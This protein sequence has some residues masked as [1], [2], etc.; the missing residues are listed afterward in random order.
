MR[1]NKR[2]PSRTL[3]TICLSCANLLKESYELA[4]VCP[5]CGVRLDPDRYRRLISYSERLVRF[6]Y[7][8]RKKFEGLGDE[9]RATKRYYLVPLNEAYTWVGLVML[10][11]IIGGVSHDVVKNVIAKIRDQ[12]K[13][14]GRT[15]AGQPSQLEL[16][17][18]Q[19]EMYVI[20]LATDPKKI[21]RDVL[22]PVLEE[23]MVDF[24][25][26][27]CGVKE[28][29]YAAKMKAATE[30][31]DSAA[32]RALVK[33]QVGA[34]ADAKSRIAERFQPPGRIDWDDLW[35]NAGA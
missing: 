13:T 14:R 15:S 32:V 10:S 26:E 25:E 24:S 27:I 8:Y 34:I 9:D 18:D 4:P 2:S 6:G 21:P 30:S 19:L 5:E 12:V 23:M 28:P 31:A 1:S 17:L 3:A 20:E 11:G 29:D 16:E 35:K 22:G 33:V 7:Q